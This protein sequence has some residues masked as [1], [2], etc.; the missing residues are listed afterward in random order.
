MCIFILLRNNGYYIV[1]FLNL[2]NETR[3]LNLYN[4]SLQKKNN[5]SII[6]ID[7]SHDSVLIVYDT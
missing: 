1:V 3:Q 4:Y 5:S 2:K 7:K 6:L